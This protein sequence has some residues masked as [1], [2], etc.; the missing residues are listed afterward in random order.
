MENSTHSNGASVYGKCPHVFLKHFRQQPGKE[1]I[2]TKYVSSLIIFLCS[3]LN[4]ADNP[5]W[6]RYALNGG[7]GDLLKFQL[8]FVLISFKLKLVLKTYKQM[9][10]LN[11]IP[12]MSGYKRHLQS[13][14]K[15]N[16]FKVVKFHFISQLKFPSAI[17]SATWYKNNYR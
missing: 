11:L 8:M 15:W 5:I 4:N 3:W 13:N 9:T 14:L 2:T 16:Q 7:H 6:K 12:I 17:V 1:T 10:S